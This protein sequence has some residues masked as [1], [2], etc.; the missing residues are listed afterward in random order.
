[1]IT[2]DNQ[3]STDS[4]HQNLKQKNGHVCYKGRFCKTG[5]APPVLE[6]C[7]LAIGKA[8]SHIYCCC[9]REEHK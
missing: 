9:N 3:S 1:M 4:I 7:L 6:S 2:L 5:E 8:T